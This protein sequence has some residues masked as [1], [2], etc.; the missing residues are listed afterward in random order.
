MSFWPE[1][2]VDFSMQLHAFFAL[3]RLFRFAPLCV[4][5]QGTYSVG[6]VVVVVCLVVFLRD[7]ER[8][9]GWGD[10]GWCHPA[11]VMTNGS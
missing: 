11:L 1:F 7:C 3:F 9:P 4:I 2:S 6:V 8:N 5:I 10:F